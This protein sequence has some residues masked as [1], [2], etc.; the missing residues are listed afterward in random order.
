ML[1]RSGIACSDLVLPW[2]CRP[3]AAALIRPLAWEI[4]HAS[5]V[6]LK[7][8]RVL[9]SAPHVHLSFFGLTHSMQKFMD[10]GSNRHH[11]SDHAGPLT[12]RPPGN[13][14][15]VCFKAESQLPVARD[16]F[17]CCCCCCL[18]YCFYLDPIC[19]RHTASVKFSQH[20]WLEK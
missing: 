13:P 4:P 8:R 10:Q 3:A 7:R 6:V 15:T 2:L 20:E 17:C 16:L 5:N 19:G 18:P 11:S 14:R 1:L 9:C 12:A